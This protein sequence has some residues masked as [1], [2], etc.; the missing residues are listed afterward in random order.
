MPTGTCTKGIIADLD[1]NV[2][3][4]VLF[5]GGCQGNLS[6]INKLI[7]GKTIEEVIALFKGNTCGKKPTSCTDQ[8]AIMFEQIKSGELEED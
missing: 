1:G 8:L 5:S 4:N 7:Q 2:I 3:N 6:A